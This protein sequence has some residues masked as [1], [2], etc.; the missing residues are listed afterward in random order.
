LIDVRRGV[1]AAGSH[2]NIRLPA[3][4]DRDHAGHGDRPTLLQP[5]DWA[6]GGDFL[7]QPVQR[8]VVGALELAPAGQRNEAIRAAHARRHPQLRH[9]V[10]CAVA[11]ADQRHLA[12][13]ENKLLVPGHAPV[14]CACRTSDALLTAWIQMKNSPTSAA[15]QPASVG[16]KVWAVPTPADRRR[17][18]VHHR[19][20]INGPAGVIQA[21]W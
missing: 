4:T 8:G 15:P 12:R 6:L 14:L 19:Q 5:C 10:T 2:T 1:S 18:M 7:R 17:G 20:G 9:G 16:P 3:R 13:R 11:L 21:R